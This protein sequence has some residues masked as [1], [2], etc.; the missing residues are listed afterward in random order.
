MTVF[1]LNTVC[2]FLLIGGNSLTMLFFYDS[3]L[4]L[5][6]SDLSIVAISFCSFA[7]PCRP[8]KKWQIATYKVVINNIY[9]TTIN[10][11]S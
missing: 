5:C 2:C 3:H 11:L 8:L 4:F 7:N 9:L 6:I 10:I 1:Y